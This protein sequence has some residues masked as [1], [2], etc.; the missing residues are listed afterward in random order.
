M[1]QLGPNTYQPKIFIGPNIYW[2]KY[3]STQIFIG[4]NIYQSG[5]EQSKMMGLGQNIYCHA[6]HKIVAVLINRT[7]LLFAAVT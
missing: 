1:G 2:P 5:S 4:H 6:S 3:L 7:R